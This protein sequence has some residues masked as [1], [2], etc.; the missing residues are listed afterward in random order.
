MACRSRLARLAASNASLIFLDRFDGWNNAL[1][2]Q[3]F[4]RR[5]PVAV[6]L[7]VRRYVRRGPAR[8]Y[9]PGAAKQVSENVCLTFNH[10]GTASVPGTAISDCRS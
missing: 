9:H 8:I 7:I 1:A 10:A 6:R 3:S 4:D 5:S 2:A